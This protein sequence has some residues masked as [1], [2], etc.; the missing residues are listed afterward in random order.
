LEIAFRSQ[1]TNTA[2]VS[3]SGIPNPQDGLP[4]WRAALA[5]VT[6]WRVVVG[7]TVSDDELAKNARAEFERIGSRFYGYQCWSSMIATDGVRSHRVVIVSP[8][9]NSVLR[10]GLTEA[11]ALGKAI[12]EHLQA[13]PGV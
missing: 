5:R 8:N 6:A 4:N 3:A 1:S 13:S 10:D 12:W 11:E 7:M 2:R 9:G